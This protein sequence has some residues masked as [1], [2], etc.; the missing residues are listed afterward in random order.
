MKTIM[1]LESNDTK[2]FTLLKL[3]SI[4]VAN[5]LVKT[6][7]NNNTA[8]DF[9][10]TIQNILSFDN[11]K[12]LLDLIVKTNPNKDSFTDMIKDFKNTIKFQI[13]AK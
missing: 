6:I 10:N 9:I 11:S 4:E 3:D 12:K 2:Y 7:T 5:K 1:Y 8:N 13:I